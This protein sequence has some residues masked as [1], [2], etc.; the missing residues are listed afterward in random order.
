MSK[1]QQ[2]RGIK[3]HGLKVRLT[4][5]GIHTRLN[6]MA[7]LQPIRPRGVGEFPPFPTQTQKQKDSKEVKTQSE[8]AS[9]LGLHLTHHFSAFDTLSPVPRFGFCLNLGFAI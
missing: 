6:P 3:R 4:S 7:Q 9:T 1:I 5:S 2:N 8:V